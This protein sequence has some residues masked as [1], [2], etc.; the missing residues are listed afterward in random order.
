MRPLLSVSAQNFRSL[1]RVNVEL[2]PL[3]VLVGPNQAGKS[4]FLDLI[5][6]LGDSAR[7]DL[8]PALDKRGGFDRV[9]FRGGSGGSVTI[10]VMAN[11]TRHSSERAPDEY[12]LA[13]WIGRS[14]RRPYLAREERFTF[15]RTQGRGRRITVSG[16]KADFIRVTSGDE[17]REQQLQLRPTALALSTLR[18]LPKGEGGEEIDRVAQLF[19]TFRVFNPD[20]DLARQPVRTDSGSLTANASNLAAAIMHLMDT[21]AYE[22]FLDDARAMVPGLADIDLEGIDGPAPAVGVRLVERGLRDPT[23]L[24]DA[25]YGTVRVLALLALLYDPEPPLL[26]CIEEI[27]HGLHPHLLDRL[28]ERLRDA[29]RSTQFLIATHSPALVN[30]LKPEELVVCERAP[31]GSTILP[32]VESADIRRKEHA[33]HGELGLGELWFSGALGGVPE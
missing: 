7:D 31:D 13:F 4:N 12:R 23:Y 22:D 14:S 33:V 32:A 28:V 5:A 27:D 9:R 2:Q 25:S 11:V 20:V 10:H 21:E 16:G 3:N 6:F 19:S 8:V 17:N 18:Q 24:A 30:R 29:S 15:K 26:T 1:R